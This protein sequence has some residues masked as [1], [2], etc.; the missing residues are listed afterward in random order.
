M[1]RHEVVFT[2]IA[3]KDMNALPPGK[4]LALLKVIKTLEGE[5]FPRSAYVKKLKGTRI[6]LYRLRVG[7]VR[8]VYHVDE[9]T[10][11]VLLIADR[12]DL[13]RRLRGLS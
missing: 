9:D 4:R 3:E 5:P 6:P 1:G 8:V 2:R 10:V 11:V 13:R 12:K 7:D